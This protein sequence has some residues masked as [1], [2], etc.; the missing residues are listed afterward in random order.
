MS[1][2]VAQPVFNQSG[3]RSTLARRQLST[4]PATAPRMMYLAITVLATVMLYY[5]LYV[6][7][8]VTTLLLPSLNMTFTFYVAL[9][10]IGNLIGAFGSFAA[11]LADRAGRAN[12][13]V[14]GLLITGLY[15][16][17]V[18]PLSTT[19]WLFALST[20]VVGI[21][22]GICLVATPA[23]IRDFSPQVGR[24]TA[25]GFWTAGP[26][27]GSLV[28]S[29]VGSHTIP[30]VVSNGF[31]T[32]EYKIC[33]VVG[34]V[35]F[36]IAWL[37][38]RELSPGLRD[39]L[40]VTM[41]DR[42]LVEARA[43]GLSDEDIRAALRHPFR[44]LLKPDVIISAF[45]V[46][47]MLLIYYTAVGYSLIYLTTIFGFSVKN[48]NGL[49]NWNWGFN[50]IGVVV[51]GLISDRFR[52]RKPFMVIGGVGGAVMVVVYLLQ[53]GHHPSYYTLAIML[54]ALAFCLGVAYTP[55][56]ASFTETVEARNPALIAT[57][58][59]IWGFIVRVVVFA[60]ALLL[61]VVV[62][63]VTPLVDYGTNV[64]TYA[65]QYA[66]QLAFAQSH[67]A[68]VATAQKY[69]VQIADATKF[70]P[71]LAVLESNPPLFT[72]LATYSN[73]AAI[74]PK[75]LG[76]AIAAAGGGAKGIAMLS[77]ISANQTAINSV[78]AAA[79]ELDTLKPYTAQL[80][81]LSKVPPSVISYLNA[82]ASAVE[83]ASAQSPK[84][85][86][87]WYW[88]CFGGI[89]FFLLSI[90]LLRGR[91][92]PRAARLDEARHEQVVQEELAKLGLG[93]S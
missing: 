25:M 61:L 55:W 5:E 56:M 38:L 66:S 14:Y 44:Q 7:G 85:W 45:A 9:V 43:R 8:S 29:V 2:A 46:S 16:L 22:E 21:V 72:K 69:S 23:L 59:A 4:Y 19:K 58:L 73:P 27:L 77:T 75:L 40:M 86:Q 41:R 91:W 78:V 48:A 30:N 83:S 24:A 71:E 88:I 12:L 80:T 11:G 32:H 52:V 34:L 81:A 50:A 93:S 84:Q 15:T 6:G 79:P 28:V 35:V 68:I 64:Q 89:I 76:Q 3:W 13:V 67:P 37:G 20:F 47:V 18:I 62:R 70:A 90:P 31:W 57:G 26:V 92:S 54:A 17:F 39:Q 42:L 82:H 33:G 51:I 10:A 65:T 36:V 53:A 1:G 63:S 60:S 49:G 74:P 87:H